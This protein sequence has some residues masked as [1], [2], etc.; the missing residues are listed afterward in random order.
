MNAPAP[1]L[2]V[3]VCGSADRGDDGAALCAVAHV[4]PRLDDEI[5]RRL[6]V[7]RCEQLDATDLIDVADGEA[8]LVLDTVVG[9]V[10]TGKYQRLG[11]D[12]EEFMY[13]PQAQLW[14]T[15][16][17][18]IVRTAGD[19]AAMVPALREAVAAH[20]PNLP[21]TNVRTLDQHLAFSLLPAR[22]T[23]VALGVFGLLGL[24]VFLGVANL[25]RSAPL[26][27]GLTLA[28][29][30]LPTIIIAGRV[31]IQAVPPSIREAARG[32]GASP[33]QV[34]AHHV[35]PL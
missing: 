28:L 5:G 32:L 27:G 10:P 18:Y 30:T 11:E 14:S 7:R 3:L 15:G 23:G 8:C 29:M 12:P 17:S 21:L 19:P 22:I 35:L 25:P 24:A 2:R 13:F 20:D 9:V 31:S 26:V 1:T 16:M 34:V 6:E 33:L 4:L